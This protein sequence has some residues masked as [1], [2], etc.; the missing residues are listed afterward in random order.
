[1]SLEEL[2]KAIKE[3]ELTLGSRKTLSKIKL[4]KVKTVYISN[5]CPEEVRKDILHF[6]KIAEIKVNDLDMN[7]LELGTLVKKQFSVSVLS[8]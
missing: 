8:Y 4:G 6:S 5:D 7:G 2:N 1:M 3:K